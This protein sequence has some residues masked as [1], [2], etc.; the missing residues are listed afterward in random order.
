MQGIVLFD[1]LDAGAAVFGDL[2]NVR[3]F[4]KAEADVGVAKGIIIAGHGRVMPAEEMDL[5]TPKPFTASSQCVFWP[6][7]GSGSE[8]TVRSDNRMSGALFRI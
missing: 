6:R 4:H 1:H 2:V 8:R 7:S 3:P 5:A